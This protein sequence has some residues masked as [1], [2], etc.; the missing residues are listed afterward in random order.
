MEINQKLR[1]GT[2][3]KD[4]LKKV[5]GI[6]LVILS[7]FIVVQLATTFQTSYQ[8][9]SP[10]IPRSAVWDINEQFVFVALVLAIANVIGLILYFF[11][12]YLMVIILVSLTLIASR[13]I[14]I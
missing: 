7:I 10:V 9:V 4:N 2:V 1:I 5:A 14:Y 12:K 11:E 8:L 3:K 6:L 13:Y